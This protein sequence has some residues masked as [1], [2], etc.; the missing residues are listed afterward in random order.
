MQAWSARAGMPVGA[1]MPAASLWSLSRQW[2]D[3][4]LS[5]DW[6]P[7]SREASQQLLDAAGFVG[8]FWSLKG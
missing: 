4:R 1:V 7:R 2:F 6:T 5:P 3:G 8:P